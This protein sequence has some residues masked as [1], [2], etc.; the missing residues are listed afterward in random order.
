MSVVTYL[1][2]RA[3]GAVLSSVEESSIATSV[4]TLQSRLNSH[5]GATISSHFK[6][7]SYPRGTILP[8]RMDQ[9]SD[10]DYMVVFSESGYTPQTYLNRLKTFVE[11]YYASSQIYQS[12]PTIVL[13]LNHIKF[14]LVPALF[15]YRTTY[16]IPNGPNLWQTSD[17]TSFSATLAAKNQTELYKI[18]P[19]I[20]LAKFWNADAG[21]VFDSYSFEQWIVNQS[22]W[23]VTNLRDYLFTLF[24][25][26]TAYH[27]TAWRNDKINRAKRIVAEVRRL[28]KADM[29]ISAE[30]EVKKLIPA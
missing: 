18:K 28:E 30:L 9:N 22:F 14:E 23:G 6:F 11:K 2:G 25:N 26:M 21:Y 20:R 16:Q 27:S 13:E 4:L 10:I 8:R 24:D 5:F 17:P 7:G 3:S 1:E 29:P 15:C 19:T 12:S